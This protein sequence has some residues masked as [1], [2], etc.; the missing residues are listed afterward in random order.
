MDRMHTLEISILSIVSI[1]VNLTSMFSPTFETTQTSA[2][3]GQ[4]SLRASRSR[5]G[6]STVQ[7]QRFPFLENCTRR[8]MNLWYRNTSA[9]IVIFVLAIGLYC[10]SNSHAADRPN[11]LWITSEDNSP[12]LGCYGD[13]HPIVR[14]WAATGCLILKDKAAPAKAK[15]RERLKDE[16]AD[17]IAASILE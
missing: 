10:K 17:R 7:T 3:Q 2:T 16:W 13:P 12:Y 5:F 4:G 9:L 6:L 1:H 14:Y 11:I 8:I 15:L